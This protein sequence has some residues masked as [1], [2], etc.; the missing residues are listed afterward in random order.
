MTINAYDSTYASHS[1]SL[2]AAVSILGVADDLPVQNNRGAA[3]D[4]EAAS[5]FEGSASS[6]KIGAYKAASKILEHYNLS[7]ISWSQVK[8]LGRELREAGL[9]SDSQLLDLTAPYFPSLEE[10]GLTSAHEIANTP[11]DYPAEFQKLLTQTKRDAPENT[12]VIAQLE[13]VSTLVNNLASLQ[14]VS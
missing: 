6:V 3:N 13:K 1:A 7:S 8:S 5:S 2:T 14:R 4:A 12:A 9:L 11:Y 10:R